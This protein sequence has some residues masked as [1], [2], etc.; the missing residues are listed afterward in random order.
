MAA[1]QFTKGMRYSVVGRYMVGSEV[2]AY[3]IV[4]E[5]GSQHKVTKEQ[6]ILLAD[7]GLMLN[8]RIQMYN[9]KPLLRGKGVNLGELPVF[10]EK[11]GKLKRMDTV[12]AVRPKGKESSNVLG[13]IYIVGRITQGTSVVQ[14]ITRDNG[15]VERIL[16]RQ[17]VLELAQRKLIANATVQKYNGRL[18]LRGV[19]INLESLPSIPIESLHGN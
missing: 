15:G 9:G 10:D 17:K 4:G 6:L 13:Q 18:L 19:G 16:S 11:S 5:D 2:T 12:P 14:Y 3:H 7:R 8:C 1:R